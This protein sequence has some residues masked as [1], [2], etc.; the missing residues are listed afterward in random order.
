MEPPDEVVERTVV[1][2]KRRA[3]GPTELQ[4]PQVV[5]EIRGFTRPGQVLVITHQGDALSPEVLAKLKAAIEEHAERVLK[6]AVSLSHAAAA[7]GSAAGATQRVMERSL[8]EF[9][10]GLARDREKLQP[11]PE[12]L[13]EIEALRRDV[14][15]SI[16]REEAP[17]EPPVLRPLRYLSDSPPPD[18]RAMG[19]QL[20][21]DT[22]AI[23]RARRKPNRK[24]PPP[25]RR[26]WW[27]R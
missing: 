13:A 14:R 21:L 11:S 12:I 15:E 20:E 19:A 7:F 27:N 2:D 9:R 5:A 10:E 1:V 8:R 3:L 6:A 23:L 18:Y 25:R 26:E 16:L 17:P 24:G 4:H 22:E